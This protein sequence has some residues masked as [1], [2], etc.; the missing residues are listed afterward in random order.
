MSS[1]CSF[2]KGFLPFRGQIKIYKQNYFL[3]KLG[4][5]STRMAF[6]PSFLVTDSPE[7]PARYRQC[8]CL[9]HQC[10][11]SPSST[12]WHIQEFP[13]WENCRSDRCSSKIKQKLAEKPGEERRSKFINSRDLQLWL[14][15]RK[16]RADLR[17]W[18]LCSAPVT[19][20]VNLRVR[21]G[22]AGCREL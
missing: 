21:H 5:P 7:L 6:W 10:W 18:L 8:V 12:C 11:I 4:P 1:H 20:W 16:V 14:R 22:R 17:T 19:K 15:R 2:W 13:P 9:S 3:K